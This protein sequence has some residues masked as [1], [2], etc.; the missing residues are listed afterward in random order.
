MKHI[1][2]ICSQYKITSGKVEVGCDGEEAFKIATRHH[3]RPTSKISHHDLTTKL[4]HLINNSPITW[5]FRHVRGHHDDKKST[6]Q[7]NIWECMNIKADSMAKAYLWETLA[8]GSTLPFTPNMP[9]TMPTISITVNDQKQQISSRTLRT[10]TSMIAQQ[11]ALQYWKKRHPVYDPS[12]DLTVL[13]HTATNT[14][15]WNKKWL[16]K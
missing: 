12:I 10:I 5:K 4:H 8:T 16:S 14:A 13:K 6:H 15:T 2:D 9:Q 3:Y 7:L 11:R 1:N